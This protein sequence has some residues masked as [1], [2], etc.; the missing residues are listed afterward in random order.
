MKAKWNTYP[1]KKPP[2]SMAETWTPMSVKCLVKDTH[3]NEIHLAQL[4][5]RDE[6]DSELW[7]EKWVLDGRDAYTFEDI[8]GQLKWI[9][10][11]E[12]MEDE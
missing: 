10:V 8:K 5:F 7:T 4:M 9:N 3:W 2:V 6:S 12:L 11:E 1:E